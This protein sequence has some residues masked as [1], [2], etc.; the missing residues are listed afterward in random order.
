MTGA[1]MKVKHKPLRRL[2]AEIKTDKPKIVARLQSGKIHL[3]WWP[4]NRPG[5][6]EAP[7]LERTGAM[8]TKKTTNQNF[9]EGSASGP[10]RTGAGITK[11]D[12]ASQ[13]RPI[14]VRSPP[15]IGLHR[16]RACGVG[17]RQRTDTM[18][19]M[20]PRRDDG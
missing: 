1:V 4:V 14:G 7:T 9:A 5:L 8:D 11:G 19:G 20:R 6:P 12:H 10:V 15:K 17:C 2:L 18:P 16:P 13:W 3:A